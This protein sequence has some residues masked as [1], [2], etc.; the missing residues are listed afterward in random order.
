MSVTQLLSVHIFGGSIKHHNVRP[1][2]REPDTDTRFG[3]ILSLRMANFEFS[4]NIK[5][6]ERVN[7]PRCLCSLNRD[8][9]RIPR[10]LR[11]GERANPESIF[12]LS[13]LRST[14]VTGS[15]FPAACRGEGS[16]S[17]PPRGRH[18]NHSLNSG[19]VSD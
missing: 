11:R 9:E 6:N 19:K 16:I 10:R 4:Q 8:S 3:S 15:T 12:I 7:I 18:G 1:R 13:V 5:K 17:L 2:G 14:A